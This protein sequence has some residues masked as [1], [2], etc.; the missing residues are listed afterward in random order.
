MDLGYPP[1]ETIDAQ[2]QPTGVSVDLARA[3]GESLHRPVKF[4]N[5]PFTGLIP[6]LLTGKIDLILSSMTDTA[7]REK[8]IAF[9]D[10]YLSI[11]L[12]V[13]AGN[14][15]GLTG[16]KDLDRMGCTIAVRQ[17]TT[18]QVWAQEHLKQ[19]RTLVLDKESSAVLE[20]IQGKADGFLYDQMSVWKNHQEH[21]A[22]TVALLEP[23]Q[24]ES[25]AFGVRPGD[26]EL[27][28]HVNA[29]IKAFRS[30]GGFER[31][32][33]TYLKEQKEAFAKA[34]IPFYF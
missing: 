7:E 29:F 26:V 5:I 6:S 32:G 13:L 24:R 21:P 1:F 34:G 33:D 8:T 25:W 4:Q 28:A 22:E 23:V 11:G 18:G 27:R 9:S 14:K 30:S 15:S 31:L 3:L 20:V 16:P 2:G 17:G 12:A 19:A 10:P